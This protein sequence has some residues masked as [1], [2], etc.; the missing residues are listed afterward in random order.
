MVEMKKWFHEVA[1]NT[2]LRMVAGK[3]YFEDNVIVKEEEANRCLNA[4][5][6]YMR[7]IGV[8]TVG[9][10][11]VMKD[12]VIKILWMLCF[13]LFMEQTF[14]ALILILSSKLHHW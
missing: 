12:I 9:D 11:V 13:L 3:R 6:D 4:L 10:A 5:R 2:V 7:L 8:F 1:F 14:M